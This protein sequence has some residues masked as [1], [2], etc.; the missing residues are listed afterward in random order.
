M[1]PFHKNGLPRRGALKSPAEGRGQAREKRA[2][3]LFDAQ[4]VLGGDASERGRAAG[5]D[6]REVARIVVRIEAALV[7]AA[8]IQALDGSAVVLER[9]GVHVGDDAVNG[10]LL[11]FCESFPLPSFNVF[12]L[13]TRLVRPLLISLSALVS[14]EELSDSFCTPPVY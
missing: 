6:A 14:V 13:V 3:A 12:A 7:V 4:G 10:H 8:D 1:H 5:V 11:L 9:L 2:V